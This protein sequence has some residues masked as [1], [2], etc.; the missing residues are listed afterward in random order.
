[1]WFP[2]KEEAEYTAALVF[3]VV[4]AV[5]MGGLQARLGQGARAE[6]ASLRGTGR[7]DSMVAGAELMQLIGSPWAPGESLLLAEAGLV[8]QG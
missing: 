3:H 7:Q 1:M 5:C 8:G 6:G 4:Y 2:S